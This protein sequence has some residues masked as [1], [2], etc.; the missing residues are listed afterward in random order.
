MKNILFRLIAFVIPFF[1]LTACLFEDED[2][3]DK[4]AALRMDE[5]IKANMALL[6]SSANGWWVDYY[7]EKNYAMGGY[8]MH[9]KFLADGTAQITCEAAVN[10]VPSAQAVSSLWDVKPE[11]GSI[12]SF[13]TYND[14]LQHFCQPSQSDIDGLAGDYEFMIRSNVEAGNN[15]VITGRRNGNTLV[16]RPVAANDDVTGYLTRVN[17]FAA[18]SVKNL[19][20]DLY[21]NGTA[22]G[23]ATFSNVVAGGLTARTIA[24]QV[25]G[26]TGED[27]GSAEDASI[28]LPYIFTAN[29]FS[30]REPVKLQDVTVQNFEW[31]D[32]ARKY[33]CTDAGVNAEWVCTDLLIPYS[34]EAFIGEFTMNYGATSPSPGTTANALNLTISADVVGES[35]I[36]KGLLLPEYESQYTIRMRYDET[37][38]LMFDAQKLA[39]DGT[40]E[41]WLAM[42]FY[43][44]SGTVVRA[45]PAYASLKST[46]F[47]M[48][49]PANPFGTGYSF[50]LTDNSNRGYP[51]QPGYYAYGISFRT[52]A[53]GA[54]GSG[55]GTALNIGSFSDNYRAYNITLTKK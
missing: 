12:L 28:T 23:K 29:G 2:T 40:I 47:V 20:F 3:F 24:V 55:N 4:S 10:G 51:N 27:G 38:G 8:A 16:M 30:L 37:A 32:E 25:A 43:N 22:I 6:T 53:P 48:G 17:D 26:A 44:G 41:S 5:E 45:V 31:N 34:Y 15:L 14:V 33:V 21:A 7:P 46:E 36:V 1:L 49:T 52:Y 18:A 39:G 9:W 35:Y 13:D 11:L 54:N 42:A 19:N 50:K